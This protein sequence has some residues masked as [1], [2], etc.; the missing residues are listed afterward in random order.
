M[1]IIFPPLCLSVRFVD[2]SV[3]IVGYQMKE[4]S[5]SEELEWWQTS[6][7]YQV[8]PRSFYDSN[9]DGVGDLNGEMEMNFQE[10]LY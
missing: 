6:I 4:M 3:G 5:S 10:T 7:I 8:Y 2:L 1:I 9:G